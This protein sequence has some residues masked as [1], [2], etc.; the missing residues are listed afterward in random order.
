MS[1]MQ[2]FGKV[3]AFVG[4]AVI[5]SV[6]KGYVLTILWSWFVMPIFG[7]PA[8]AVAP[9]IGFALFVSYLTY[10]VD[11]RREA[12]VENRLEK[13]LITVSAL[14]LAVLGVGW[15]IQHFI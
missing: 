6:A 8:L 9:A 11:A 1:A 13:N 2:L 4:L 5:G 14:P 15:V 12:E 7:L 3:I 10:Q